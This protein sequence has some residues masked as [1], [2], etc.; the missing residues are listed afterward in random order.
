M[1]G[2]H[3]CSWFSFCE[4]PNPWSRR[5]YSVT[6]IVKI[7]LFR[8]LKNWQTFVKGVLSLY[9][10]CHEGLVRLSP[11]A[12]IENLEIVWSFCFNWNT[13]DCLEV[14]SCF[15]VG[16]R[17]LHVHCLFILF[18]GSYFK[19]KKCLWKNISICI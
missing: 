5:A 1:K 9:T 7:F 16:I 4:G 19:H 2:I 6:C 17:K 15:S 8:F 12:R 10:W 14:L 13:C 3:V 11:I 18:R